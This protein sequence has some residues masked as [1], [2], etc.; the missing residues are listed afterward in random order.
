MFNKRS[1]LI[2]E[3]IVKRVVKIILGEDHKAKKIAAIMKGFRDGLLF[4]VKKIKKP[5]ERINAMIGTIGVLKMININVFTIARVKN[6]I[7]SKVLPSL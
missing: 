1:F 2:T 6:K 4:P 3:Q 7:S 5:I